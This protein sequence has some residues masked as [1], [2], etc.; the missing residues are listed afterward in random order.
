MV[1]PTTNT[2]YT[3]VCVVTYTRRYIK[4]RPN[5]VQTTVVA[6]QKYD[7]VVEVAGVIV[8]IYRRERDAVGQ[9]YKE[10][11]VS[12]QMEDVRED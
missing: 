9:Q 11:L 2:K 4:T 5:A 6:A 3:R 10:E 8:H 1:K 12:T 7:D